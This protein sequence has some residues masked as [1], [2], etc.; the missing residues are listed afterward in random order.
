[1]IA[2]LHRGLSFRGLAAYVLHD[3]G[4]AA[5][6]QRVA[7]TDVR[8]L[9]HDSPQTA[10]RIMAATAMDGDRLKSAAGI[11]NTGRKSKE[12]VL[13]LMLAW[14]PDE[15]V[16]REE[17]MRAALGAIR[18]LKADDHQA[19]IVAHCDEPQAHVHIVLNRV[20]PLDGRILSSSKE[21]LNLSRWAE[22]YEKERGH[23]YCEERV[24]NNAARDRDEFVR[25]EPDQA[26][27]LFEQKAANE[28]RPPPANVLAEERRKDAA[29]SKKARE[30]KARY[31][32][33]LKAIDIAHRERIAIINAKAR[34][35]TALARRAIQEKFRPEWKEKL[36]KDLA[37]KKAFDEKEKHF[38][39]RVSNAFKAIDF[40]KL[41]RGEGGGSTLRN[42]FQ[43]FAGAG[44]RLEGLRRMQEAGNQDIA[45]RQKRDGRTSA[46]EIRSRRRE[47]LAGAR[48]LFMKERQT[49]QLKQSL[50][51]ARLR[52]EWKTR[53]EQRA[54]A[55]LRERREGEGIVRVVQEKEVR[56][57]PTNARAAFAE[58]NEPDQEQAREDRSLRERSKRPARVRRPRR[59]RSPRSREGRDD[60]DHERD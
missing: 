36:R 48:D 7:W 44:A 33:A 49:L 29:V 25:G 19:L 20:N 23:I 40:G 4:R 24:L 26:R 45:N 22:R 38:F 60:M 16:S 14:H 30:I 5:T 34:Q 8:N 56:E 53:R 59:P 58:A 50:E 2:K 43:A 42:A 17:M 41:I 9:A 15:T 3:K 57:Q 12:H 37:E 31:L 18:A 11:K 55:W 47:E 51:V 6:A 35:A 46:A 39:G 54:A 27:H 13:H 10:W 21:K 28:N 52:T 1:M 32:L